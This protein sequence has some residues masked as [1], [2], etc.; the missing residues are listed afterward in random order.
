MPKTGNETASRDDVRQRPREGGFHGNPVIAQ[1]RLQR[2]PTIFGISSTLSGDMQ[3]NDRPPNSERDVIRRAAELLV[4]RLPEAWSIE[5]Q[6][7]VP[8]GRR[9]ADA[10][11]ALRAPDGDQA[12]IVI[13]AKKNLETRDAGLVS[14]QLDAIRAEI[15][16]SDETTTISGLLAAPYINPATRVRL[17][18]LGVGY[19]DSTGNIRLQLDRPALFVRDVGTDKNP[20]RGPGRPRGSFKGG[21]A[22]RVFRALADFTPPYSV[23]GLVQRSGA[24]SGVTYRVVEFLER[25]GILR[26]EPGV[27]VVEVDWR[28]L[29]ERWS[30]EYGFA[31]SPSTTAFLEPRGI[32]AALSKL[33]DT[34]LQYALTSSSASQ[35]FAPYAPVRAVSAYVSSIDEAADALD[36][37]TAPSG[38]NV[39]LAVP[40]DPVAFE[41]TQ[42][43]DALVVAAP[44]QIAADLLGGPGRAPEEGRILL[45]WME[46]NESAW[47]R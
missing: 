46:D 45:E 11:L 47:R 14:E 22:A 43:L 30:R 34:G 10:V 36:L 1:V 29:I 39:L 8:A 16:D 44:S 28:Q 35:F 23:P 41:R 7:Q 26:R 12:R 9:R 15:A 13:E 38:G 42:V 21:T 31:L 2:I 4:D 17:T 32:D 5:L 25:E 37:R 20:W 3:P 24:S 27:G 19:A 18:E 33:R 6:E 40:E